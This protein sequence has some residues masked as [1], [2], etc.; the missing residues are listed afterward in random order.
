MGVGSVCSSE[1]SVNFYETTYGHIP[2]YSSH[3]SYQPQNGSHVV[4]IGCSHS[5]TEIRRK[6]AVVVRLC[7]VQGSQLCGCV[8]LG[9]HA[10]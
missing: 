10:T 9:R 6:C 2:E 7:C 8:E 1:T 5:R 4:L 3:H